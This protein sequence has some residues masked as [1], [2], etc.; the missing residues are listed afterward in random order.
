MT[1]ENLRKGKLA[2]GSFNDE[3]IRARFPN[4][5]KMTMVMR[6]EI[7]YRPEDV[8]RFI[9]LF[10]GFYI[11][12]DKYV[13]EEERKLESMFWCPDKHFRGDGV[14]AK[15]LGESFVIFP[16]IEDVEQQIARFRMPNTIYFDILRIDPEDEE[17]QDQPGDL[18]LNRIKRVY[19]NGY[20][21]VGFN[22]Q[23]FYMKESE[24]NELPKG[25]DW[26]KIE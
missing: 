18:S 11:P 17:N 24:F 5:P 1:T 20:C 2:I 21:K 8:G 15:T 23:M 9:L 12:F 19:M 6:Y 22:D 4:A 13:P 10:Y 14:K 25:G 7:L 26:R 3:G 16:S